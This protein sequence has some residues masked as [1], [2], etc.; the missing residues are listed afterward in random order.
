MRR[1][2][3]LTAFLRILLF[4]LVIAGF[5]HPFSD[6]VDAQ[7]TPVPDLV[8]LPEVYSIDWNRDGMYIAVGTEDGFF[9]Y[10]TGDLTM[11]PIHFMEGLPVKSV[12]FHPK[13]PTWLAF[14]LRDEEYVAQA[15]DIETGETVFQANWIIDEYTDLAFWADGRRFIA[16]AGGV[17]VIYDVRGKAQ[18]YVLYT[19]EP[20]FYSFFRVSPDGERI[21]STLD[22]V[23]YIDTLDTTR[24][25]IS[26][27]MEM[28]FD[29]DLT[30][31][32]FSPE[33]DVVIVG[34]ERGSLRKWSLPELTYTSAIRAD[35]SSASNHINALEF[36]TESPIFYSAEGNPVAT[37]RV[38]QIQALTAID[39]FGFE[40]TTAKHVLDLALNPDE[41]QIAVLLD[42]NTVQ[43]IDLADKSQV[44]RLGLGLVQ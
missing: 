2:R 13:E 21:A 42:D 20:S 17:P 18:P 6:P 7:Q 11:P 3:Y 19:P 32:A 4:A 30:A 29:D 27:L 8:P 40:D 28:E 14:S 9:V 31:V 10:D 1:D 26:R 22:T 34:D 37:V 38:F 43:I 44:A 41:T 15:M 36:A 16:L 25:T 23:L 35:V 12:V 33:N 39:A 24:Q 5:P